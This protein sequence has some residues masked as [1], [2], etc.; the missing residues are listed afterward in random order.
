[1]ASRLAIDGGPPLLTRADYQ[2][3]PVITQDERQLIQEVLDCGIV[4]GG[5][6]PQVTALEREWREYVGAKY[7]LTTGSGTAALHMGL[8]AIDVGPGDEV[9]VPAYT[10]LATASSVMH[11]MAIPVFV[12]IDPVTYTLDPARLEAAVTPRTKAIM[13]VHIQGCPADMDPILEL[14]C[15]HGLYVIEDACQAHGAMYKGRMCGTLGIAGAF[16]LNN[17]KNLCGGE[18]GLFVTNDENVLK[19]G[20]LV[21]YF[22]DECDEVTSRQKYNASIMGYM[23]RNQELPAALARG[24]LRHLTAFNDTRIRNAEYLSRELRQIPG[25]IPPVCPPDCKHVYWFYAVRFDPQ[26]AG[27]DVDP[28]R[29]RVAVEKA[30]FLE[31][32]LVGQWQTMPVPA[33][34]VF[35]SML[36]IGKRYPWAINE[37]Q[38][39]HYRYDPHDYPVAQMLC[40]TYTNVH[41]IHPP[42]GLAL[43]ERVVAAFRKVFDSLGTVLDHADDDIRPGFDGRLYGVG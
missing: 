37:A 5:T 14:A 35:Q 43:N 10:F 20:D 27:V 26:A 28:R 30:L 13:P 29:F 8:A 23:Y 19:K 17:L 38:G 41:S 36:G 40:D 4:A 42:N 11:Q 6:A 24:Q 25:V 9:L 2:N 1:M 18:G 15:R 22:G 31:G 7:C 12:D 33:Q 39:I 16:S 3:W 34:D 21:R 32:V